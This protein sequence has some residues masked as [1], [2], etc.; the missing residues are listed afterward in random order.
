MAVQSENPIFSVIRRVTPLGLRIKSRAL[1][2]RVRN[3]LGEYR[4]P[5]C[6]AR[7]GDF[8]PIP[9]FFT[10]NQK[11]YGYPFTPEETETCNQESYACPSC[12]ASDRERLYALYLRNC[13][14]E[15]K[16]SGG[17]K[18]IDFAPAV[19]LTDFIRRQIAGS[20]Q[21]ISYRTADYYAVGVDDKVD[22]TDLRIYADGQFDFFICSHVLEHVPDDRKALHELYRILKPGG[23]GILMVP[24]ILTLT[25]TDEDTEL[26]DEGERWR[27]FGQDDHVRMYS[28]NDFIDRVQQSGFRV[29][30]YGKD[31]FGAD[32][33]A[34][35]GITSQSV[36]YVVEK[37]LT[38]LNH[39]ERPPTNKV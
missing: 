18:I 33:F 27:R 9:E 39:P 16:K 30:Q 22:I 5:V 21:L 8:D 6:N 31:F 7:V 15:L 29:R 35:A 3:L 24:I 26:A 2:A 10:E 12:K 4:C 20:E 17:G 19:P 14:K 38:L 28:K 11:K 13:L 36:L 34:R 1:Q 37:Q 25:D 32:V 23:K